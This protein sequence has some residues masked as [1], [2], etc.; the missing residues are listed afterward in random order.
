MKGL[1]MLNR[2]R[3][4]I[5]AS[6]LLP[7]LALAQASYPDKPIRIINPVETVNDY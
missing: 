7:A 2:I 6:G 3:L 1:A 5:L 4:L